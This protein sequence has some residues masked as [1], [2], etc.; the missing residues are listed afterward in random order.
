MT[1]KILPSVRDTLMLN[2]F[3]DDS[4][5]LYIHVL[6]ERVR[7]G[8]WYSDNILELTGRELQITEMRYDYW[9]NELAIECFETGRRDIYDRSL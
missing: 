6:G 4:T 9:S 3:I 2:R 8:R 5:T 7:S 1:D